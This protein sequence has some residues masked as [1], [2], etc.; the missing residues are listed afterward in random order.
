MPKV[1]AACILASMRM[2]L[3]ALLLLAGLA[4]AGDAGTPA[5]D[6]GTPAAANASPATPA[7]VVVENQDDLAKLEQL[8]AKDRAAS[9]TVVTKMQI[10]KRYV[11]AIFVDGYTLPRSRRVGLGVDVTIIDPNGDVRIERVSAA[12]TKTMDPKLPTLMLR[13]PLPMTWG[14]T[15]LEGEYTVKLKLYDEVRGESSESRSKITVVR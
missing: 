4:H 1:N 5:V 7:F 10:G 3:I 2:M 6:A 9:K 14:L 13:P 8:S 12:S 11:G 15:D